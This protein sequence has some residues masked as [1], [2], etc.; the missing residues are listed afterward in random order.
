MPTHR[1]DL[2]AHARIAQACSWACP[3]IEVIIRDNSG[4][5]Q[6]R[7]LIA[8][9]QSDH[10]RIVS[11]DPCDPMT[12][13]RE[14]IHLAKGDFVFLIADDD[15]CFDHAIKA[16]P[17]V[18]DEFGGDSSVVGVTGGYAIETSKRTSVG[19]YEGVNADDLATRLTGYLKY[20]GPNILFYSPLRRQVVQRAFDLITA[21]PL[22]FSF[23]DQ[24][25][26]LIYLLS[27]KFVQLQR[28]IYCYD[29][30]PW[31]NKETAQ[32]RDLEFYNASKLDP[33]I[34]K[35]HWLLC[36]F[37]GAVLIAHPQVVPSY[38]AA[39]RQQAADLWFAALFGRLQH[40]NRDGYDSPFNEDADRLVAK[41]RAANGAI[42]FDNI[43]T[44]IR[45]FVALGSP[46]GARRYFDY[47]RAMLD[48][49]DPLALQPVAASA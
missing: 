15:A 34:N 36:A 29:M 31:E 25:L 2:V 8:R 10:C 37:E 42:T 6:K 13:M 22:Q 14:V 24:L 16:L 27:G 12:N 46:D 18:I 32:Q 17:G 44:D 39:Q 38:S 19:G 7:E 45:A 30:G 40:D 23:H 28:L 48:K 20:P 47:W 5:A 1:H 9:F 41:W 43:L 3:Q 35:L 49:R 4:N 11:V 33:A 26:S 21:M